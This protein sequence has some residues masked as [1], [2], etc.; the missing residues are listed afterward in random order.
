MRGPGG[1]A[2]RAGGAAEADGTV[3]SRCALGAGGRSGL[4]PEGRHQKAGEAW[5][6]PSGSSGRRGLV[7][8]P[9][10]GDRQMRRERETEGN[11]RTSGFEPSSGPPFRLPVK[12][13]PLHGVHRAPRYRVPPPGCRR[14]GLWNPFQ[15]SSWLLPWGPSLL[16]P[17]L[18][19]FPITSSAFTAFRPLLWYGFLTTPCQIETSFL[20][21][22]FSYPLS[23][24]CS[25]SHPLYTHS[26]TV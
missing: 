21:T 18:D 11:S 7:G 25:S 19:L 13:A 26:F 24:P 2:W 8:C 15:D 9:S 23:L 4:G 12:S 20:P 14:P 22:P 1:P 6:V 17:G 16:R 5:S 3:R 10:D